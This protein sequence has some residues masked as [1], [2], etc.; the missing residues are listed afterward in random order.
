[1]E[2]CQHFNGLLTLIDAMNALTDKTKR[3]AF[4]ETLI[5]YSIVLLG[6]NLQFTRDEIELSHTCFDTTAD[7]QLVEFI[8]RHPPTDGS[9]VSLI[10]SLST[11]TSLNPTYYKAYPSIWHIPAACIQSRV[12]L[13]CLLSMLGEN[14]ISIV[15][16]SLTPGQSILTDK[17][18][19][20]KSYTL[21]VT[22]SRL[23]STTLTMTE[24]T[25]GNGI[26]TIN[27]DTVLQSSSDE[28]GLKTIFDQA[29]EQLH[30]KAQILFRQQD[31]RL[32]RAQYLAMHSTEQGGP[33]RDSIT[34]ICSDICSE[35]L[36]LFILYPNGRTNS[37]TNCE[38]WVPNI[39]P[40]NKS[41]PR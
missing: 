19:V 32:W 10:S 17:I 4:P 28:N 26:A 27:F 39:H 29:Y 24:L 41:I 31:E 2:F 36:P 14:V 21:Y 11:E 15:D 1:M 5:L 7:L 25:S 22:K 16:F 33:Y 37:A 23:F 8:N 6:D 35:R 20:L 30:D 40:L 13:F 12:K 9:F 3:T 38:R 34:C 18:R